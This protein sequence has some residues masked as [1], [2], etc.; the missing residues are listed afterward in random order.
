VSELPAGRR[1]DTVPDVSDGSGDDQSGSAAEAIRFAETQLA[2]QRSH[3]AQ[4]DLQVISAILNAHST[5]ADRITGLVTLQDDVERAVKG[6]TD[7]DTPLGARDFQRYLLS[8]IR[9]IRSSIETADLDATSKA[10][11]SAA[12]ASL[13]AAGSQPSI[14]RFSDP[15][16]DDMIMGDELRTPA[17][18][19]AGPLP[20]DPAPAAT[21][22]AAPATP[23]ATPAPT[24]APAL[25]LPTFGMP[26]L[27]GAGIPGGGSSLPALS[28]LSGLDEGALD[29]H[30][31]GR[32]SDPAVDSVPEE[33]P[34]P[35]VPEE[36]SGNEGDEEEKD[37][38][39][40][41][42]QETVAA[43]NTVVTLPDGATVEAPSPQL[44]KVINDAVSGTPIE[45]AF[46][47][48]GI[49]I[50]EP[51]STVS[52][53]VEA[54]QLIPGDIGIFADRYALALGNGKALSDSEVK[55]VD[56]IIGPDFLG[57]LRPPEPDK[58]LPTRPE[59]TVGP[60]G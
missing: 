27:G 56:T 48:Q 33:S 29:D 17:E 36:I 52:D 20:S 11:L 30:Q 34:E 45:E 2:Q 8:K 35:S 24:S 6:R 55:S 19:L 5:N 53:P 1:L 60:S 42:E 28:A 58:P 32:R 57:W 51:G 49:T 26:S 14:D 3:T 46:R 54:D 38:P 41:A 18:P 47:Q 59:L 31:L 37:D 44:A 22:A 40:D 10:A 25:P 21:P 12:I 39:S 16:M 9:E 13:Y 7:L 15:L 43:E 50:P 23:P 4:L